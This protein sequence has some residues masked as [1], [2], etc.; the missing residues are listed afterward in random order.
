MTALRHA[1]W[2]YQKER[3]PL[4]KTALLAVISAASLS[5]SAVMAG[6]PLPGPGAFVAGFVIAVP[7]DAGL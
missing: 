4:A 7:S 2:T 6:R 3:S 1:L 5:A